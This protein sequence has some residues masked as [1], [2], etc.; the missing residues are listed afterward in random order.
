MSDV[1]AAAAPAAAASGRSAWH[2]RQG[3][4]FRD[5]LD[6]INPLQHL[7]VISSLY[8]WITGDRPGEAAQ[9]A[10][11]ALYGGPIGV[12][13][14]LVGAML[15]D[16]DGHDAGERVLAAL[17][18]KDKGDQ[19][20]AV[21]DASALPGPA[22]VPVPVPPAVTPVAVVPDHPPMP[23]HRPVGATGPADPARTFLDRKAALD[24]E[25]GNA[26]AVRGKPVPLIPPAGSLPPGEV[27]GPMPAPPATATPLDI[28]QKM[29]DA[30]DKY[31]RMEKERNA[32]VTPP[33]V[34]F[35]M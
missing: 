10:G 6:I 21:A 28:S 13:F 1:S 19:P 34:D 5:I 35:A 26:S 33:S 29:M 2:D 3:F 4:G 14:S 18:D 27:S 24:R 12:A 8:R 15:Q 25:I 23:L 16:K 31:M 11:D 7:P 30:L 9:V 22:P 32:G 17:F 20:T